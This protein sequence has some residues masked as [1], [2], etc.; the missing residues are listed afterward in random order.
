MVRTGILAFLR[1]DYSWP[2]LP[3][4]CWLNLD[5]NSVVKSHCCSSN[6]NFWTHSICICTELNHSRWWKRSVAA[7]QAAGFSTDL[8]QAFTWFHLVS[9]GFTWFHLVSPVVSPGETPFPSH[10]FYTPG[11]AKLPQHCQLEGHWEDR[12]EVVKKLGNAA[13]WING[14]VEIKWILWFSHF[15]KHGDLPVRKM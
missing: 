9:A 5:L 15:I 7:H 10:G 13:G 11:L 1:P 6:L 4:C 2:L 3:H 12:R 8:F 14:P